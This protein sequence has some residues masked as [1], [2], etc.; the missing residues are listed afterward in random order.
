MVTFITY[1]SFYAILQ[2]N[3]SLIIKASYMGPGERARSAPHASTSCQR[4]KKLR[5]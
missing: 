1:A 2:R 3:P 5:V 4:L